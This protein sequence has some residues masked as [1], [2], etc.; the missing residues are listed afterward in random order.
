LKGEIA[1]AVRRL[2]YPSWFTKTAA[3]SGSQ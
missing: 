2:H 3:Q 1:V